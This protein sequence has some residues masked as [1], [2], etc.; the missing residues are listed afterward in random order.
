MKQILH[1]AQIKITNNFTRFNYSDPVE[2]SSRYGEEH[3]VQVPFIDLSKMKDT[4][5][6][7]VMFVGKQDALATIKGAKRTIKEI[8]RKD[9]KII[10]IDNFNHSSFNFANDLSYV[11]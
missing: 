5:V 3:E 1:F 11:D 4:K 8:C 10:K 7:I 2:N 6:P 9:T